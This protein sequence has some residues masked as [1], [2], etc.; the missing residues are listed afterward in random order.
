MIMLNSFNMNNTGS[1]GCHSFYYLKL[2]KFWPVLAWKCRWPLELLG[3]ICEQ[4][5]WRETLGRTE[6]LFVLPSSYESWFWLAKEPARIS[7]LW[8]DSPGTPPT[9]TFLKLPPPWHS[10]ND[11]KLPVP[12]PVGVWMSSAARPNS[13]ELEMGERAW[14]R[15][16]GGE[17]ATYKWAIIELVHCRNNWLL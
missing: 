8:C 3:I 10:T 11:A 14:F 4:C 17:T 7:P 15:A 9:P 5:C 6:G 16:V 12:A 13:T 2:L 1:P